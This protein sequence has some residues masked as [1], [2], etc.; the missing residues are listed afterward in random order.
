MLGGA[1]STVTAAKR[2]YIGWH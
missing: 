1:W 2:E